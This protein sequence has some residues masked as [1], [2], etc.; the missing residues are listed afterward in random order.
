MSEELVGLAEKFIDGHN[1][2][3]EEI[4][5]KMKE[6]IKINPKITGKKLVDLIERMKGGNNE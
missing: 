6:A 5:K 1:K 3:H 2:A 4:L